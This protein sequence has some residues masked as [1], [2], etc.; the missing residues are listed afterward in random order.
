MYNVDLDSYPVAIVFFEASVAWSDRSARGVIVR[1]KPLSLLK[2]HSDWVRIW[3]KFIFE[4][5]RAPF[6]VLFFDHLFI[7]TPLK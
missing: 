4:F 6:V 1:S 7:R 3:R 2:H 5:M